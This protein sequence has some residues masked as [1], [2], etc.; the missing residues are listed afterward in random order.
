M[1]SD[2][3]HDVTQLLDR[4][5]AG[6][7]TATGE[8]LNAAYGDLRAMA[9]SLFGQENPGHTLQPT[10]LVNEM[11]VR[12]LDAPGK[13]WTDRSHF[14][15]A[16]AKVMRHLLIDHAR[17]KNAVRRGEGARP[18]SLDSLAGAGVAAP[19][20]GVDLVVLDETVTRLTEMDERLGTVFELRFLAGLT[21]EQ[22]ALVAGVSPRAVE[23]DSQFIRAWLHRE[24]A[25]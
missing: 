18:V 12:M 25:R 24:L 16:A 23:Q 22:T 17:A 2:T 4:I 15:K 7:D 8:L 13:A 20:S 10:A 1:N 9:A 21:V 14:F 3:R 19:A 11:C 5:R 6:E